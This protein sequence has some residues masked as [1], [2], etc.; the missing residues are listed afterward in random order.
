MCKLIIPISSL[1]SATQE[2]KSDF[3]NF[4]FVHFVH[5]KDV[6]HLSQLDIVSVQSKQVIFKELVEL[7]Y[8]NKSVVQSFKQLEK[9]DFKYLGI[10][11]YV[12]FVELIHY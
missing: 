9:S 4:G 1:Q 6:V 7:G 11:H 3:K 5:E 10:I 12:H 8:A 2:E